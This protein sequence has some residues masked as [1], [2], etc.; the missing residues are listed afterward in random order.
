MVSTTL[1]VRVDPETKNEAKQLFTDMGMDISTAV[2]IFLRQAITDNGMP[3]VI[4]RENPDSVR[5]RYEAEHGMTKRFA[6]VA[7]LMED[8]DDDSTD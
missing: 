6:S 1:T 5:A 2:N 8:L 3:F 4:H 7:A